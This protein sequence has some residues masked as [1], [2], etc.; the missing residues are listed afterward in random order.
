[1]GVDI[2]GTKIAVATVIS[3][4]RSDDRYLARRQFPTPGTSEDALKAIIANTRELV[5]AKT[6]AGLGV[7]FGGQVRLDQQPRLRS[8][9]VPGWEHVDLATEFANAFE[10]A[11][12]SI[13]NDGEAAARGEYASMPVGQGRDNLAYIT[14]STGVG[15]AFLLNGRVHRGRHGLAAEVGHLPV[16]ADGECLCGGTGHLEAFASGP[17]IARFAEAGLAA[18]PRIDSLLR[19]A[20][21]GG[22]VTARDVDEA[23]RQGDAF[24]S[25][26]L[27]EAGS[28]VGR[29]VAIIGLL[30]DPDA[31][32]VGGGVAQAGDAFWLPLR[33]AARTQAF[34]ST[35][36]LPARLG[37]DSALRGALEL[38][39]DATTE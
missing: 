35:D 12:T 15:G 10:G 22:G 31:V 37:A 26:I 25:E 14:V 29:A 27:G 36:V 17:A 3:G 24:A 30:L 19:D 6:I 16:R 13:A 2:G 5:G 21:R 18:A 34:H 33:A 4:Q 23:A 8:L 39:R 32:I 7:S 28:L 1:M 38:A 9:V 20:A 11:P